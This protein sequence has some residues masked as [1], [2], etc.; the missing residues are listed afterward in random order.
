MGKIAK[1]YKGTGRKKHTGE[2]NRPDVEVISEH[3]K[4]SREAR[5]RKGR[6]VRCAGRGVCKG[7]LVRK[8]AN[9]REFQS[10]AEARRFLNAFIDSVTEALA[11]E[12]SVGIRGFGGFHAVSRK[13]RVWLNP[14]TGMR[15]RLSPAKSVRFRP[16]KMLK[17]KAN[18][19]Y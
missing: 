7:E 13:E 10:K 18:R 1:L 17:E 2:K 12:E 14:V 15:L 11:N 9:R 5:I 16:G 6:K 4:T 8:M 3:L 19:A